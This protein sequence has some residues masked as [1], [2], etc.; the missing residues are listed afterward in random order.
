MKISAVLLLSLCVTTSTL[1]AQV[2]PENDTDCVTGFF[3]TDTTAEF[4]EL[5][6][7]DIFTCGFTN[8]VSFQFSLEYR[9]DLLS[10]NSCEANVLD[11]YSCSD[12]DPEEDEPVIKTI[13]FQAL[14]EPV[15][16]DTAAVLATLCF[17]VLEDINS[18]GEIISF[19]DDLRLEI[20]QGDPANPTADVLIVPGCTGGMPSIV[21][22]TDMTSAVDEV[23]VQAVT[24]GP[25]PFNDVLSLTI[26]QQFQDEINVL[27][28]DL[29]G[30]NVL[31]QSV[32]NRS[33]ELD[34][35]SISEG[36][37]MLILESKSHGTYVQKLVK[38]N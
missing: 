6:C 24:A 25:N 13:W 12:L 8:I 34:L 23:F 31:S 16:L 27:V 15:T 11:G 20:V 18:E 14:A 1:L 2:C 32:N 17:D 21:M 7:V 19:S 22:A 10:F 26:D 33:I 5:L 35:S 28:T 9:D 30:K 37:Y 3:L 4:G 38:A 36:I 29:A